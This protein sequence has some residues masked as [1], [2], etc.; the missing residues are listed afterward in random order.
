MWLFWISVLLGALKTLVHKEMLDIAWL[1]AMSWWWV[2]GMFGATAVWWG[3]ADA[4]G[5][6]RSKANQRM[7]ARKE[8]R[9]RKNRDAL[10]M[11]ARRRK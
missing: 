3:Y 11:A 9:Q 10:G 1:S 8:E 7:Q 6:T 5:L 4:S 2:S